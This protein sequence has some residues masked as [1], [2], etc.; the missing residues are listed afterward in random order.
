MN[1]EKMKYR[2]IR[3]Y[4][5]SAVGYGAMGLSHG[6]GATPE[7]DESIRLLRKALSCGCNFIDTAEGYGWGEN[8]RLVG[9]AFEGMRDKVII[10]TKLHLI[11]ESDN[12]AQYIEEHLDVSLKNLRTDY[13][14]VYYIHRKIRGW[15][16]S[17]ATSE[18]IEKCN[19][20]TPLTC[21]QNEYSM[22]ERM[23]ENEIKTCEKLGIA[24]VA[25]SPMASGFLSGKYNKDNKYE[26]DDVRRVITRFK[27]DNVIANQPLLDMLKSFAEKKGATMAQVSLAWMLKKSPVVI[28]IP[29]MRSDQRIEENL[30]SVNVELTDQEYQDLENE[31]S[32]IS[33]HGNRTDK[34]IIE[35]LN[36][37]NQLEESVKR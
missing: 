14:D 16:V 25:F 28:P 20:I 35:G 7:H 3:Q 1:P 22:M 29:G 5:L 34:D 23:Y 31:L 21:V 26:G 37:L 17:Q 15:G 4:K 18:Q 13:V 12:W 33:I 27:K 2:T 36:S 6:Y 10:C 11:G 8:E 24:F 32:K 9:E 19:S 30:S